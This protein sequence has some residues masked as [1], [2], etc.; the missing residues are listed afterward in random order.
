MLRFLHQKWTAL[1]KS[2]GRPPSARGA[3]PAEGRPARHVPPPAASSTAAITDRQRIRC[4]L[5]CL[6]MILVFGGLLTR[7]FWIQCV[8]YEK[9]IEYSR[10][11]HV[12][13]VPLPARRGLILDRNGRTLAIT[14]E[15]KSVF[16]DP[17]L[18]RD[19]NRTASVLAAVLGKNVHEIRKMLDKD[20]RFVYIKRKISE[21]QA[22]A[23]AR[24]DLPGVGFK[25]EDKRSYPCGLLACH[26]LGFVDIDNVGRDGIELLFDQL[27]S[28][29]PG[30]REV[31]QDG[32]RNDM[33]G[34][35]LRHRSPT[36]GYSIV[37]TIDSVIQEIAEEELDAACIRWQPA[38]ASVIVMSPVTGE[39]LAMASRP[40]FDPNRFSK[41]PL[42]NLRNRAI[43]DCY[44]PGST[45]KPIVAAG[46]LAE[47]VVD[48]DTIFNCYNGVFR[49]GS[50]VLHDHHP[51]SELSFHDAI[52]KSSNIA[53]AQIGLAMGEEKLYRWVARYGFGKPTG[54]ELPGE[55]SG[56]LR[57][58]KKWSSFSLTS[59]P[60]GH[61][62]AVTPIQL[63]RAFSVYANGGMLLMPR[64]VRGVADN[65]GKRIQKVFPVSVKVRRA[66]SP[67]IARGKIN[68]IL[69]DVVREGTGKNARSRHYQVAGKTGTT[70]KLVNG[71]YSHSKYIGSFVGY[72]PAA[73]PAV[74]VLVMMD[75]PQGAYYGSTVAAP[76]V[77]KIIE[78]TLSYLGVEPDTTK[79]ARR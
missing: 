51:Y 72:A 39:V 34:A 41:Y 24:Q 21:Q 12:K 1:C 42:G 36:H 30:F 74:C 4:Y 71:R 25:K 43:T 28:G 67:E 60:M 10:G 53:L 2:N 14:T 8:K 33:G 3:A 19:K 46:G 40:A 55:A 37:L 66:C 48:L 57:P 62:V 15:V 63:V 26:V 78:R 45:F 76:S 27:L 70:Q 13:R 69:V 6:L 7:L 5:A 52:V 58:L 56:I 32:R 61:E 47:G 64:V 11:I 79:L 59:V 77:G 54:I 18:V 75:E 29:K 73:D 68:P 23:I 16:A 50:R 20:T 9:Y 17:K 31:N 22:A 35:D 65:S 38:G 49:Y 44:E